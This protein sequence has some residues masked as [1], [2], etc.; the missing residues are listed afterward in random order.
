MKNVLT[1]RD[2]VLAGGISR[3][4]TKSSLIARDG[5]ERYEISEEFNFSAPRFHFH[6][7]WRCAVISSSTCPVYSSDIISFESVSQVSSMRMSDVVL[8]TFQFY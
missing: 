6:A 4:G 3:E 2:G 1:G 7:G 8:A 5:S